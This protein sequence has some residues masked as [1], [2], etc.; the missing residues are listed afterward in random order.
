M[1]NDPL[2]DIVRSLD[3]TGG[4][5]LEAE[6]TAPWAMISQVSEE[7]CQP[8]LPLPKQVMAYHVVTEGE[9][10]V[11]LNDQTEQVA[12]AG[13]VVFF[14]SNALH[15]LA[16]ER[17]LSP[18]LADDL[19]LP[20]GQDGLASIRFGGGGTKTR[21]LCGFIASGADPNPLLET[22]PDTLVISIEDVSTR[23]WLEASIAMAAR[24]LTAGRVSS[25]AM[26]A[27]LSELLLIEALR[28]YLETTDHPSGWLAG[29]ADPHIAIALVRVHRNLGERLGV[30]TLA[31]DAG[32]SRSAFVER[33]TELMGV[34]PGGYVTRQRMQTAR[35][36]LQSTDLPMAQI[37][38][39][40]GYDA[41]EAFSRAF[42]RSFGVAP[43]EWR[44][45]AV[46]TPD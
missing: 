9:M 25:R 30:E 34:G 33:F 16:S 39:R 43:A 12:R 19:V 3:L 4:V 21:I 15:T 35:L 28:A 31:Q 42:K 26:M 22:L 11:A 44:V 2:S 18:A 24:E 40:V 23:Q 1:S 27:R 37:A 10:L 14:P 20:A 17:G 29:M 7:D 41:P 6:L 13:D 5:F 45:T 46:Q 32:M 36:L 38:Y 8:I